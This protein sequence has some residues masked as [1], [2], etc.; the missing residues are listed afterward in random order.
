MVKEQT[1]YVYQR[2]KGGIKRF[3]GRPAVEKI[4]ISIIMALTIAIL[5]MNS[6]NDFIDLTVWGIIY[7]NWCF[8]VFPCIKEKLTMTMVWNVTYVI[9]ALFSADMFFYGLYDYA[10]RY[11]FHERVSM[12]STEMRSWALFM[13]VVRV[14]CLLFCVISSST[15]FVNS[16]SPVKT[17]RKST[18]KRY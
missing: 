13:N 18:R 7:L 4:G 6:W 2:V 10:K 8:L 15:S 3:F 1:L 12:E 9:I 11:F 17:P 5:R 16:L 14:C